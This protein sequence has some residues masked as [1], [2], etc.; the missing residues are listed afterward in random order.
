MNKLSKRVQHCILT[1]PVDRGMVILMNAAKFQPST[2]L[3]GTWWWCT[4]IE[5]AKA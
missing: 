1:D 4:S 2:N 3:I 5:V